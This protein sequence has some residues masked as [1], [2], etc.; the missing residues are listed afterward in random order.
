MWLK[1]LHIQ[2]SAP[3]TDAQQLL[4]R[5]SLLKQCRH[6]LGVEL[7]IHKLNQGCHL[8]RTVKDDN[9]PLLPPRAGALAVAAAAVPAAEPARSVASCLVGAARFFAMHTST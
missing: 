1:D 4:R 7:L 3:L 8:S 9:S 6:L 5:L 2:L